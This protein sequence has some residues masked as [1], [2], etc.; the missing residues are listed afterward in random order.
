MKM[1]LPLVDSEAMTKEMTKLS[2]SKA[3]G[4]KNTIKAKPEESYV[5]HEI[6]VFK[7]LKKGMFG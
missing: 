4:S 7:D 2:I 5:A 1:E 6:E 3:A